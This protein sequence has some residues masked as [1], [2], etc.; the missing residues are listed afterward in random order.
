MID[1]LNDVD[2][3]NDIDH[4]VFMMLMIVLMNFSWHWQS[5]GLVPIVL[6]LEVTST[7]KGFLLLCSYQ[8]SLLIAPKFSPSWCVMNSTNPMPDEPRKKKTVPYFPLN[9]GFFNS[10]PYIMV[11]QNNPHIINWVRFNPLYIYTLNNLGP[12]L[13]CSDFS[14]ENCYSCGTVL[15]VHRWQFNMS[16]VAQAVFSEKV[17]RSC[18]LAVSA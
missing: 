9:P 7:W 18:P 5:C 3:V 12:F 16:W 8:L 1:D 6:F 14:S 2:D 13:H 11:Y 4:G 17:K 15:L 10:D